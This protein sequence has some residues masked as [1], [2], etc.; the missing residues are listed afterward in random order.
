M[1]L[2][3]KIQKSTFPCTN[4]PPLSC[5]TLLHW[6]TLRHECPDELKD[7]NSVIVQQKHSLNLSLK[8]MFFL[9]YAAMTPNRACNQVQVSDQF[10]NPLRS[11]TWPK[12]NFDI[13]VFF[14]HFS[15]QHTRENQK[16]FPLFLHNLHRTSLF[17]DYTRFFKIVF[18]KT[19]KPW[20]KSVGLSPAVAIVNVIQ[21]FGI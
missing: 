13:M 2:R 12:K 18:N 6:T 3:R 21:H 10:L 19:H 20:L 4:S 9:V 17:R 5:S 14:I 16:I 1:L 15:F 11:R 8:S 7:C